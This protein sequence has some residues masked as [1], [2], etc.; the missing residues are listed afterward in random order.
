MLSLRLGGSGGCLFDGLYLLRVVFVAG[1][2]VKGE[3]E[4][5]CR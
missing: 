1:G 2:V 3:I 5:I 4:G